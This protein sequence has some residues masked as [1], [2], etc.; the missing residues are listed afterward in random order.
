[1]SFHFILCSKVWLTQGIKI[2]CINKW[3]LYLTSRNSQDQNK[4]IHYRR[5]CKVLRDVIKLAKWKYYNNLLTNSTSKTKTTW[6]IINENINKR[7]RRHDISSININ[8]VFTQNNQVIADTFNSY[9]LSVAQHIMANSKNSNSVG[10]HHNP[11]NYLRSTLTQPFPPNKPKFVSPKEI[12][13]VVRSLRTKESHG[14]DEIPTKVIKQSISFISSPLTYICKLMLSSGVFPTR[15]KFAQVK[16][17]YKK[18]ERMD[19]TNYRPISLLPSFS[20][21]FKKISFKR[22]IQH[23]DCNEILAKE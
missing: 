2:S 20:K 18:G 14:Y 22:L 3:K 17:L 4:K 12:E 9:F 16:P 13:N 11:L 5:Y 21:M 10:N 7:H 19:L 6:N 15:L 23:L 8:G 1:M